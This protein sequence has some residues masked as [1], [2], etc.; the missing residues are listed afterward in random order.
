MHLQELK[1]QSPADLLAK[2]E[3]LEIENASSMRKQDLVF[4]ILKKLAEKDVA[5]FGDGVVEILQDGFGFLRSP[6]A[7]YLPGPDDIYVSPSQVRRYGLRTGDTIEGQIRAPKEGERYFALHKVNKVNFDE[8][9]N[10]K[11]RINFDN[12]TPLYPDERLRLE[13]EVPTKSGNNNDLS[14]RV[15]DLVAPLGKGQRALVVAPPRTGK[16]VMLQNIAHA[17]TSNHPEVY[18]IVLLI[19][20]RPE[21]VTDMARSVKGEVVSSTFDEPAARHVQVAEMVI[22]KA[23]RLVEQKRDVVILLDSIT[24]LARAYNTVVPS[25]G[26]VLTGGV[27][28][29]AL[30]R[31][32]RFF[33]AARNIE[34]GGSLTIIAT[35]LIETGSRMDEV[36]FEEFKG[37]GN[38]EIVMDRKLSDKRVFPAID[39]NKSGT[40]KEELL[41]TE[42]AELTKM[43]VLRRILNPMGTIEAMEFLVDKLKYSKTNQDFFQSMNS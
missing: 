12:L 3:E 26:K 22:E 29:N 24:R 8:P 34:E 4:A 20:E 27:D 6:E 9:E 32:K 37:T 19:D 28:A 40:R 16:T 39:I 17:I 41:V 35:A 36:I 18:L 25:S 33:G 43:W 2:A 7:N 13:V 11:Y 1:R 5:I 31:P 30:Q 42:K 21:E 23:K 10:L 38:A 14:Q 15:I